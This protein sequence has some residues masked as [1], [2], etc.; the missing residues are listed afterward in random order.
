MTTCPNYCQTTILINIR[1]LNAW[2][3]QH[4]RNH[5]GR[6]TAFVACMICQPIIKTIINVFPHSRIEFR[7]LFIYRAWHLRHLVRHMPLP[8]LRRRPFAEKANVPT[9]DLQE[10][11]FAR[12]CIRRWDVFPAV[13]EVPRILNDNVRDPKHTN[14][15]GVILLGRRGNSSRKQE[16]SN[17]PNNLLHLNTSMSCRYCLVVKRSLLIQLT[18]H[19]LFLSIIIFIDR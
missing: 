3:F 12:D 19:S 2:Q 11:A 7:R 15:I 8:K 14:G 16:T 13:E 9:V 4:I 1:I 10:V 5:Y 17:Q 18:L 6:P